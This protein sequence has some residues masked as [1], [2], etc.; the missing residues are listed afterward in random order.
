MN[1]KNMEDNLLEKIYLAQEEKIDK[2]LR[3]TINEAKAK[4]KNVDA[5]TMLEKYDNNTKEE[6]KKILYEIEENNN[7]KLAHLTRDIY[8]QGFKDGVKLIIECMDK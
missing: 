3:K 1:L 7:I 6:M 8:E 2:T 4:M 5:E